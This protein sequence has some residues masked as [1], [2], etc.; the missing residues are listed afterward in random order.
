[1][2]L[3]RARSKGSVLK[4]RLSETPKSVPVMAGPHKQARLAALIVGPVEKR[5]PVQ[6]DDNRERSAAP[7]GTT[8]ACAVTAAKAT[9]APSARPCQPWEP[10]GEVRSW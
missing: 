6:T 4:K 9:L 10:V 5:N 7:A 8:G 2:V 1:M 3:D